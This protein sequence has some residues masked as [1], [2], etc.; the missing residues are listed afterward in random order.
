MDLLS[1]VAE[2][3][4][5]VLFVGLW[6]LSVMRWRSRRDRT[7]TLQALTFGTLAVATGAGLLVP[8]DPSRPAV[9]WMARVLIVILVLFPYFLHQFTQAIRRGTGVV[10]RLA[11]PVT[12]LLA[13]W[14]LAL[15]IPGR[16]DP[17]SGMFQAFAMML[18]VQWTSLSLVA[19]LRLWRAGLN[20][21]SPTRL[22]MRSL[23]L[24]ALGLSAA[25]ILAGAP[26]ASSD[27]IVLVTR[28][29]TSASAVLFYAGLAPPRMLRLLWR[30]PEERAAQ[31]A[32]VRLMGATSVDDVV[33]DFLPRVTAICGAQGAALIDGRGKILGSHGISQAELEKLENAGPLDKIPDCARV[34]LDPGQLILRLGPSAP[35]FDAEELD[36]L[37]SLGV[38]AHIA[39]NRAELF[40]RERAALKALQQANEAL[41]EAQRVAHMGSW[42]WDVRSGK[43]VWSE[44]LCR[45]H[46]I[47]AEGLTSTADVLANWIV[48]EDR[49]HV[50]DVVR[51]A[52]EHDETFEFEYRITT[53]D[54][55]MRTLRACGRTIAENGSVRM[56]G[57]AQDVTDQK[58]AEDQERRWREAILK[59]QQ[60]LELNDDVLQGL[61]LA[62]YSLE[63]GQPQTCSTAIQNTIA[64][65]RSIV[66]DLLDVT[67]RE[68]DLKPGDLVREKSSSFTSN[69]RG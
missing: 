33:D 15:E 30:R 69:Q 45:I 13:A 5:V 60:A 42:E 38:L 40:E 27:A 7:A 57:T 44:E 35:F 53:A 56:V 8:D 47:P 65:A 31:Q 3:V 22:R 14:A 63:A 6:L 51:R 21:P 36:L 39:I 46:G 4:N 9:Q 55:P 18:L 61:A 41:A 68:R 32:A 1:D 34:V 54:G 28:L 64:A 66:T 58:Q 37:R 20:Q 62:K 48:P 26:S 29:V 17:R 19:T 50:E 11:L 10:D 23:G 52:L 24:G 67:L 59:Q 43:M 16:G 49:A 25:I 12:L 2:Y